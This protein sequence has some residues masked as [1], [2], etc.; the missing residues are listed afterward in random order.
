LKEKQMSS[1]KF[2]SEVIQAAQSAQTKFLLRNQL[3]EVVCNIF[4]SVTLAQWALESSFGR[5]MP[6]G[7]NNPFG[8][9]SNSVSPH[10]ACTTNEFY[11][12]RYIRTV[13]YFAKY[14]SLIDAFQAHA[15]LL[16]T[17]V[18]YADARHSGNARL[19]AADLSGH[20]A[21]DPDYGNK[22]IEIMNEYDLYQYDADLD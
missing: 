3:G 17:G 11:N 9:K 7:S 14:Y 4:A 18:A 2:P 12:G 15:K 8:I 6:A 10:V 21:T 22:L 16:A 19:F 20:Y 13:A 5:N 1:E